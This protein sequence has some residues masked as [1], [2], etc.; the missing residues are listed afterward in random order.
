[1]AKVESI[2]VSLP[3]QL[4][5]LNSGPVIGFLGFGLPAGLF[6]RVPK[7]IF[8]SLFAF[9]LIV[10]DVSGQ[11]QEV[12]KV[13]YF[14]I[15]SQIIKEIYYVDAKDPLKKNGP[16]EAYYMQGGLRVKGNYRENRADGSWIRYFESGKQKSLH[17][18]H[19]GKLWGPA[20]GYFE[21]GN[22][23]QT[24]WYKND[25]EDS[26]WRYNYE[27]GRIKSEGH[28]EQGLPSGLWRYFHEDST[29]KAIAILE[30]GRGHYR[31]FFA[32]GQVRMEGVIDNGLSDSVWRYYYDNGQLKAI[33]PE[34]QGQRSG[35]WKFYHPNGKPSSEGHF[36][37]NEKQGHWK[38]Y[39]ENG[40]LS[41]EGDQEMDQKD[42]VW[43]FY[44]PSG[45]L[46]G[47][48]NFIK[49]NGDYQEFYDN[50]K[51]KMKGKMVANNYEGLWTFY[52]E[53]GG[54]EGECQYEK[55]Y[56][57]YKGYYENGSVKMQG[58]MHNGQKIGSWDLL[59]RDGKLIGHYK[60]FYDLPQQKTEIKDRNRR[61][62]T[63][64]KPRNLGNPEF[65]MSRRSSRHFIRK[66]N[67][68]RGFIVAF[69]PFA[70]AL[71]SLP[72]SIEYFFHD[73]LGFEAMFTL[74]RQPFFVNH[75]EDVENKRVYTLGN[76]LDLRMKLYS[77]DKGMG[78]TY[79]GPELRIS[80]FSH[81]LYVLEPT[82]T[83]NVG[84]NYLGEETKVELSLILGQRFFQH[85]NKHKSLTLD[86]YAGIGAG[87]RYAKIPDELL[88]YNKIK[89][90]KLTIPIRLGFNFGYLF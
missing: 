40:A 51:L 82:D 89:T 55:G 88:I 74:T 81:S 1:M 85:Y 83:N 7:V 49:G 21:N 76:S 39:H 24:G 65:M 33:G 60:T 15:N 77:P 29:L 4:S 79:V 18:Y 52:F 47:E 36:K 62:T 69:N 12:K 67:E 63:L 20:I 25:L 32:N 31:E 78:N 30:K 80:N 44:L 10:F 43:K 42:G 14:D 23:A 86:L 2:S 11:A 17:Y 56:G 35:Y 6:H 72:F 13:K 19:Q 90:N 75:D 64:T 73:R 5:D 61:D 48:G 9:I 27:N 45:A 38:Y 46:L 66:V 34:K 57:T 37:N 3:F 58:Q 87:F 8:P 28:Y 16:F 50:G 53:D 68:L 41:S 59:G 54:M 71:S 84:R 22:K 70:L 26:L